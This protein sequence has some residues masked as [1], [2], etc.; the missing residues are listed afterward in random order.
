M[1]VHVDSDGAVEEHHHQRYIQLD[2][3]G[4][5]RQCYGARLARNELIRRKTWAA[6]VNKQARAVSWCLQKQALVMQVQQ[7]RQTGQEP[8]V[9]DR[10]ELRFFGPWHGADMTEDAAADVVAMAAD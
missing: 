10:A 2:R 3:R 8:W 6:V 4:S 9:K 5:I 7:S 1:S